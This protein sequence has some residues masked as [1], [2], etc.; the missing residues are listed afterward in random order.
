[1]LFMKCQH[2]SPPTEKFG[3]TFSDRLIAL[4]WMLSV[5][6][7]EHRGKRRAAAIARK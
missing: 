6:D 7:L 1:M 5:E 4:A 2:C 3:A